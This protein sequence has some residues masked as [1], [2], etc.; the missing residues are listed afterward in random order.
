MYLQQSNRRTD[1]QTASL[2]RSGATAGFEISIR[3]LLSKLIQRH[4]TNYSLLL[5]FSPLVLAVLDRQVKWILPPVTPLRLP[6]W[7][8]YY[9]YQNYSFTSTFYRV[10]E[11]KDHRWTRTLCNLTVAFPRQ[12]FFFCIFAKLVGTV[13]IYTICYFSSHASSV[14]IV[15]RLRDG[16]PRNHGSIIVRARRFFFL[17]RFKS[18]SR[19][20]PTPRGSFP[21]KKAE[22]AL[23]WP[24]NFLYYPK[25]RMRGAVPP[26]SPI[27]L[28]GIRMN[29]LPLRVWLLQT[30]LVRLL[31]PQIP[32]SFALIIKR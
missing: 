8:Y 31:W 14:S 12:S 13:A 23:R 30:A 3:I 9:L 17:E 22:D 20:C 15:T 18:C 10:F 19:S 25:L 2:I 7:K 28:H 4:L 6:P 27:R 32:Y 1:G 16:Q 11:S 26:R 5:F 21:G 29:Y 24:L